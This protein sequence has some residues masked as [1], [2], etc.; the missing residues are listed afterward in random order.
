[1]WAKIILKVQVTSLSVCLSFWLSPAFI[2]R[3]FR[4]MKYKLIVYATIYSP[5]KMWKYQ[6]SMA[7]LFKNSTVYR[8]FDY[9]RYYQSQFATTRRKIFLWLTNIATTI[10]YYNFTK[11]N[12]AICKLFPCCKTTYIATILYGTMGAPLRPRFT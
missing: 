8:Y 5:L 2:I 9:F 4:R 1:M 10:I 11:Q 12:L 3:K 7:I 6:T